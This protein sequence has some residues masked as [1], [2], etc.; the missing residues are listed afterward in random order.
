MFFTGN[1]GKNLLA[2]SSPRTRKSASISFSVKFPQNQP[3]CF[4]YRCIHIVFPLPGIFFR[5]RFPKP[6]RNRLQTN[7]KT[8][9]STCRFRRRF[10]SGRPA[11]S[12]CPCP[13]PET[14]V[15]GR[16]SA[17]RNILPCFSDNPR[18]PGKPATCYRPPPDSH[19]PRSFSASPAV[20]ET[21]PEHKHIIG[22]F[23]EQGLLI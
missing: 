22:T 2:S 18:S 21:M 9:C 11:P 10:Y 1:H 15:S 20:S 23:S 6:G 12:F 16:P 4:Q 7:V 17:F 5:C 13:V 14:P 19:A 3:L 8:A